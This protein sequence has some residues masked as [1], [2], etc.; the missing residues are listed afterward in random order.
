MKTI[1]IASITLAFAVCTLGVTSASGKPSTWAK[2]WAADDAKCR[3]YG[4][5]PLIDAKA[6][7]DCRAEVG[8]RRGDN[9]TSGSVEPTVEQVFVEPLNTCSTGRDAGGC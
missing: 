1:A 6:Y 2:H 8:E 7:V 3:G 5:D 4:Y 9:R